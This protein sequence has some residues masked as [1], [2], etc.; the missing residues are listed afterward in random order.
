MTTFSPAG[1]ENALEE[2]RTTLVGLWSDR[3]Y[4]EEEEW[5][6]HTPTPPQ[7]LPAPPPCHKDT[8]FFLKEPI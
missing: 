8:F 3:K 2:L 6:S 5:T 4:D 1:A 7:P